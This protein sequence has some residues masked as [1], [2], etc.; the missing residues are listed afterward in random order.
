MGNGINVSQ[1]GEVD[2]KGF[3]VSILGS[4]I[5]GMNIIAGYSYNDSN[6]VKGDEG[7]PGN[8]TEDSGPKILS[9][10]GEHIRFRM[11]H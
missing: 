9:T 8:R 10:S 4:P 3:E 5:P 11:V 2:S 1:N 7:Y 6:V